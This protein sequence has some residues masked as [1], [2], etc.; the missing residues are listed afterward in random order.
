M[1]RMNPLNTCIGVCIAL[2][3]FG[4][5]VPA[6]WCAKKPSKSVTTMNG[7]PVR[8][9]YIRA[10]S[11]DMTSSAATQLI[12]DTCM[13][14]V[15][16]AKQADAVLDVGIALPGLEGGGSSAPG[17][18]GSTTP[19]QTMGGNKKPKQERSFSATCSDGKESGGCT[20]SDSAPRVGVVQPPA[21]WPGNVGGQL[22][23]SLASPADESQEL[24]EPDGRSKKSW[25]EQLRT[26]AGCPVCPRERFNRRQYATYRQWIQAKCPAVLAAH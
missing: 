10:A 13:T 26:A 12:Q 23:V 5:S 1:V 9:V 18:F 11:P 22:D 6:T 21:D 4:G 7:S 8:K 24:W 17:G 16:D 15:S 14:T 2:F 3:C 25:S 19:P 20:A